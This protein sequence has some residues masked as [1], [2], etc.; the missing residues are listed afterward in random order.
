MVIF[1][2]LSKLQL[3]LSQQRSEKKTIGLVPT[4]GALHAGHISLIQGCK[5]END[6]AICSI[7]VNP[8]Q[9]NNPSDLQLYPR[10]LESDCQLLEEAACDIVFVPS[11]EV[12]YPSLPKL[13]FDF[14]N[15]E[16]VMEGKF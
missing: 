11:N 7:F 10:T 14:G 2:D 13:R 6:L 8:T 12:M 3:F 15:L 16:R 4:M 1:T 9:F 5:K